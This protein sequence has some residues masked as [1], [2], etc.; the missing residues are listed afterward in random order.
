MPNPAS[1]SETNRLKNPDDLEDLIVN[2]D[3]LAYWIFKPEELRGNRGTD[4]G[5]RQE[6]FE[7]LLYEVSPAWLAL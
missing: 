5:N 2:S 7:I 6:S 1:A 4:H 3:V